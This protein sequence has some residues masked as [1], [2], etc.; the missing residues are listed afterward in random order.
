MPMRDEL[1]IPEGHPL[2]RSSIVVWRR[3]LDDPDL[4]VIAAFSMVA[5]FVALYMATHCPLPAQICM[6]FMATS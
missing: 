2:A 5:L 6:E 4:N 1:F 3:V